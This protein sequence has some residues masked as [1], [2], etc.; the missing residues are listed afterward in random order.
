MATNLSNPTNPPKSIAVR[1][2]Y[3]DKP[4]LSLQR[5]PED[6]YPFTFGLAKAV[7]ILE[8]IDAI[9]QFV[10]EASSPVASND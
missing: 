9:R 7:L 8:N 3:L 10:K 2:T 6:R 5:T 4:T 1:S